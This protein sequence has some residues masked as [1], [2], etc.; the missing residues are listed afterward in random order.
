MFEE[1][2]LTLSFN[3]GRPSNNDSSIGNNKMNEDLNDRSEWIHYYTTCRI[4]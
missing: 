1:F 4:A 2:N 3:N